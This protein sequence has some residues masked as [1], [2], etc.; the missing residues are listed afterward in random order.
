MELLRRDGYRPRALTQRISA[1]SLN[2]IDV[3]VLAQPGGPMPGPA[4][5]GME[6]R[7]ASLDS[8]EI[9]TLTDW[10]DTG[11]ALLFVL[12]HAPAPALGAS[13]AI[14]LG[15]KTWHNGYAN[16]Q[17][18]S[19]SKLRNGN[20]GRPLIFWQA[21][22]F[23]RDAPRL[24]PLDH[25]SDATGYQVPDAVLATH[26]VTAGRDPRERVARVATFGGSAFIPPTG[27]ITLL[28]MPEKATS[29]GTSV[30]GWAQG[31]IL[32][33]GKGRVGL[34]G[35]AGMFSGDPAADNPQFILNLMHW[36]TRLL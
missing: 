5:P 35:E 20:V 21:S 32:E 3:L 10:V 27:A 4:S 30:A 18:F 16:A 34:F 9:A 28:T 19:V 7:R 31:A 29:G 24:G 25:L 6:G 2:G 36:L 17:D 13:I 26:A 23:P 33:R 22:L 11:G 15:V 1:T 8:G 14:A 12:D